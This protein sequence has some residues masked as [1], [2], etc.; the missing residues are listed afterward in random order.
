MTTD[1]EPSATPAEQTKWE[2]AVAASQ[3][4]ALAKLRAATAENK[5]ARPDR[6]KWERAVK[7]SRDK[8][9]SEGKGKPWYK[10]GS[11]E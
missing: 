2:R 11:D 8:A 4:R 1:K 5:P 3:E 10:G 7:R 9:A 6:E